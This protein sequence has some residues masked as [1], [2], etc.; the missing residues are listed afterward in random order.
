MYMENRKKFKHD[1]II[2]PKEHPTIITGGKS[3][4]DKILDLAM[5]KNT[6]NIKVDTSK[7]P[8]I[9]SR[10]EVANK[11]KSQVPRNGGTF[12]WIRAI[13]NMVRLVSS[14]FLGGGMTISALYLVVT[15]LQQYLPGWGF[16]SLFSGN[17]IVGNAINI[18]STKAKDNISERDTSSDSLWSMISSSFTSKPVPIKEES[19][20]ESLYNST[21]GNTNNFLPKAAD[22]DKG[23][24]SNIGNMLLENAGKMN[25]NIDFS[26][27]AGDTVNNTKS[28]T[29]IDNSYRNLSLADEYMISRYPYS[30]GGS[31]KPSDAYFTPNYMPSIKYMGSTPRIRNRQAEEVEIEDVLPVERVEE[32]DDEFYPYVM[33][34]EGIINYFIGRRGQEEIEIEINDEPQPAADEIAR[35]EQEE[36]DRRRRD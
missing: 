35:L 33:D 13:F 30:T 25:V 5:N 10:E 28:V 27:K 36:A 26:S 7:G 11:I 21:F 3:N 6:D 20:Y 8:K 18:I 31:N 9:I 16:M 12:S 15:I 17:N 19:W 34:V 29:N 1:S 32:V 24:F 2:K 4:E 22:G 23:F 14:V